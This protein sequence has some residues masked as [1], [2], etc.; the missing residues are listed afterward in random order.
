MIERLPAREYYGR[1]ATGMVVPVNGGVMFH[2]ESSDV[3]EFE[4]WAI[5]IIADREKK[6]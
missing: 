4:A 6:P 5:K 3:R 1:H 2:G